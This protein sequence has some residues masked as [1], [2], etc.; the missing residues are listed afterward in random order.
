[1]LHF[2]LV[3]LREG[4]TDMSECL[5]NHCFMTFP[6]LYFHIVGEGIVKMAGNANQQDKEN[7]IDFRMRLL[8]ENSKQAVT[9]SPG[10]HSFPFKLGL[11]L[12]ELQNIAERVGTCFRSI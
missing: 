11:P 7:Y 8:G 5:S 3:V 9:L 4:T 1:M 6:G 2:R 12:G 10:V